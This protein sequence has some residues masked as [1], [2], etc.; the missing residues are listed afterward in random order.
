MVLTLRSA[1]PFLS[2]LY[3]HWFLYLHKPRLRL[4]IVNRFL[5]D[6]V[7]QSLL[8][9]PA[10]ITVRAHPIT[11]AVFAEDKRHS[12]MDRANGFY[13]FSCYD[14]KHRYLDT[15]M[16]LKAVQSCEVCDLSP[17]WLYRILFFFDVP[18]AALPL[19]EKLRYV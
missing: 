15:S 1:P 7:R 8:R 14:G 2:D 3:Y 11:Q 5:H 16:L 18:I 19:N 10:G 13:R 6:H 12:V 17:F 9:Y 4:R